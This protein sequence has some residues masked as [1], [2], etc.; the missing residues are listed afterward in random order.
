METS[1][2]N[3]VMFFESVWWRMDAFSISQYCFSQFYGCMICARCYTFPKRLHVYS[4][5]IFDDER[6]IISHLLCH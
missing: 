3:A 1:R 6:H 2:L 4:W 5:H